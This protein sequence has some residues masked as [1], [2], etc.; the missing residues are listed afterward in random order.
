MT[1]A[2]DVVVIGGGQ[3]GL[4]AG[5]HL[6][7]A[8]LAPDTGYVILDAGVEP[9]GAWPH[10]WA[11]LRL[12]SP[13]EYSSLPGWR[14][15]AWSG[16]GGYPPAWHVVEYLSMYEKRYELPVRRP[17]Q[18]TAVHAED[19]DPGGR[20][21][22]QTSQ[23]SWR[24]RAVISATGTWTRPFI[25]VYPGM[26]QFQ[27]VHLHASDYDTPQPF[28]GQR[29]AMVGGGNSA[30]QILADLHQ[31][32]DTTWLTLRPPRFL[33]DHVDGR[34]LFD[35]ATA[36]RRALDAGEQDT[37][38]PA[39]LGDIV[40]LPPV[41]AACEHGA[42][43]AEAMFERLT[44]HGRAW[45]D[46]RQRPID[47]LIWCTG[48]PARPGAPHRPARA[49][50]GQ[51]DHDCGDTSGGGPAFAPARVRGLD[52]TRL[53]HPDRCRAHRPRG[54]PHHHRDP[55][56]ALVNRARPKLDGALRTAAPVTETTTIAA[57]SHCRPVRCSPSNR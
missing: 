15:P 20:L 33:P 37:G 24:A 48:V 41:R 55:P 32:A 44:E 39:G 7:R 54:R 25:P 17:V 51:A 9:G 5:F 40:M 53:C 8:G 14:M 3:A 30:A 12:F 2:T 26:D 16:D 56:R 1:A 11:S 46:R 49:G 38:G 18:V 21:V 47:A 27:G 23:G 57:P 42:L 34:T 6:R 22:V 4:A 35:V 29:V 52:R 36:R 19:L 10:T 43:V 50:T 28:A 45:T 31:V 13:P